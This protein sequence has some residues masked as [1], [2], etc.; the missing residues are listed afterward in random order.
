MKFIIASF[1]ALFFFGAIANAEI[2]LDVSTSAYC[3][4]AGGCGTGVLSW[5][6][7]NS[8]NLLVVCSAT[9][10]T[11]AAADTPVTGITYNS[12]ALTKVD[13]QAWGSGTESVELWYLLNPATGSNT[14]SITYTGVS[15]AQVGIAS[16]YYRVAQSNQT[17]ANNKAQGSAT[18]DI[19]VTVTTVNENSWVVDCA[20]DQASSH[21]IA[22]AGGDQTQLQNL[23]A[24][25]SLRAG[26]SYLS[27]KSPAG[28]AVMNWTSSANATFG[29]VAAS[30]HPFRK[31]KITSD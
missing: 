16:S 21:T 18:T 19:S 31:V 4:D 25:G 29:T 12:I 15:F 26:S 1:I 9:E 10:D 14:V 2:S 11:V 3:G 13:A 30:F 24:G 20:M 23:T 5:S 6:H 8:G 7:T 28:S 17:D 22:V 27:N